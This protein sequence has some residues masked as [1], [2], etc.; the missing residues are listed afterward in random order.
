MGDFLIDYANAIQDTFKSKNLIFFIFC[1][2]FFQVIDL[3]ISKNYNIQIYQVATFTSL[4][5]FINLSMS[6]YEL[7]LGGIISTFVS[8]IIFKAFV[9]YNINKSIIA[10]NLVTFTS[11]LTTMII[12]N[13][14]SMPAVAYTL[15]SYVSIPKSAKSYLS[16][17][18][19]GCI[20]ILILTFVL[21]QVFKFINS[22]ILNNN[23][24]NYAQ[25]EKNLSN[26]KIFQNINVANQKIIQSQPSPPNNT[27]PKQ[28]QTVYPS[29]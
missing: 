26:W 11:V 12:F 22:N 7:I 25:L 6:A 14:V 29:Q 10:L 20:V 16:S 21:L 9:Y 2:I 23:N 5:S 13:C 24:T 17:Y 27:I 1:V 8:F 19:V 4:Y 3:Q 15:M 18:I 28:T